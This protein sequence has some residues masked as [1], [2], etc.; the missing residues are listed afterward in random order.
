MTKADLV[1]QV[2]EATGLTKRDV[3]VVVDLLLDTISKALTD[4]EHIEMR[5]FGS[6]KVKTRKARIARNP[7]TGERVD[8]PEKVVPFFKASRELIKLVDSA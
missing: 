1:E 2:A 3:G 4:K 7:R 8:V 5:G 6:F